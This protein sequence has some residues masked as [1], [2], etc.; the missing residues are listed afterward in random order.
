MLNNCSHLHTVLPF[1]RIILIL[2]HRKTIYNHKF[3]DYLLG[4]LDLKKFAK[5]HSSEI[6]NIMIN[7]HFRCLYIY[8]MR[9][10]FINFQFVWFQH[11]FNHNLQIL[12]VQNRSIMIICVKDA[13]TIN[14]TNTMHII[15]NMYFKWYY[16]I[17]LI[18]VVL[19]LKYF[20]RDFIQCSRI[21]TIDI[22]H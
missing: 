9:K 12:V 3:Y 8:P 14:N 2:G 6:Y 20:K 21:T 18:T 16:I 17:T 13:T 15:I 4:T 10:G 11:Y 22:I 1:S 7:L 19:M 5:K